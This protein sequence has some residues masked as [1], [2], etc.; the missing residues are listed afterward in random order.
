V[1]NTFLAITLLGF[2]LVSIFILYSPA[3]AVHLVSVCTCQ[4]VKQPDII[5]IGIQDKF[6]PNTETI[7]AVVVMDSV[8]PGTKI[9]G[10][11]V[12]VD[13][14]EI[15]DYQIDSAEVKAASWLACR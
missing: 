14:I 5:P 3:K 4:D 15:P 13:A 6:D 8:K 7:H 11:W 10:N 1:R 2:T 9:K 12:S